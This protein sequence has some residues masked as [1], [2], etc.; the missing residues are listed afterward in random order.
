MSWRVTM[1]LPQNTSEPGPICYS[2]I[3]AKREPLGTYL[4]FAQVPER[5]APHGTSLVP[6]EF[7]PRSSPMPAFG[8]ARLLGALVLIT[9]CSALPADARW[10]HYGYHWYGRAGTIIKIMG[11]RFAATMPLP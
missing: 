7:S 5:G 1:G 6:H 2:S 9:A 10:R 8:S 4:M 11:M 3:A